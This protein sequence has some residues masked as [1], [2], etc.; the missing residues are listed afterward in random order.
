M[1]HADAIESA[2]TADKTQ[3]RGVKLKYDR[4]LLVESD[5]EVISRSST[6]KMLKSNASRDVW[7]ETT[8]FYVFKR[9][10]KRD[11]HGDYKYKHRLQSSKS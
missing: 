1:N 2:K 5:G 10:R 6:L 3:D 9:K 11:G 4:F 7:L 8:F